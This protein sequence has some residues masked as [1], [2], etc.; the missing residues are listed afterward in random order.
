MISK[1]SQTA[2]E[3]TLLIGFVLFVFTI[4]FV[5]IN[6][7]SEDKQSQKKQIAIDEV[8]E[9]IKDEIDLAY[10]SQEGYIREFVLPQTLDGLDYEVN[11]TEDIV[12]VYAIYSKNKVSLRV[13]EIS[14]NISKGKNVIRKV[15]G[16]VKINTNLRINSTFNHF[17]EFTSSYLYKNENHNP[18]INIFNPIV[19]TKSYAIIME[20]IDME[21][22]STHWLVANISS[23]ITKIDEDSIPSGAIIG[24]NYLNN[25]SYDGPN[26]TINNNRYLIKLY[27]LD[28][29][30]ITLSQG[31][32]KKE[33]EILI[34][35]H[36]ID[37][38]DLIGIYP[39]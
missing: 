26:S 36:V 5:I 22:S 8:A 17:D 10:N 9:S 24:T 30:N 12:D 18:E 35:G 19:E 15:N 37:R 38:A 27:A 11:L 28:L 23:S 7:N 2:I 20:N 29:E 6:I 1:K 34:K 21:N 3:F 32:T 25:I 33:L 39:G 13:K 4:F 16:W 14:G 31:F